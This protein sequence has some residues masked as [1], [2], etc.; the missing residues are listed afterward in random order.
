MHMDHDQSS[1]S[2]RSVR[3]W[4]SM[5]ETV[6]YP[7]TNRPILISLGGAILLLV[8]GCSPPD[9]KSLDLCRNS[10]PRTSQGESLTREDVGELIEACM[11]KRG[12]SL[13]KTGKRCSHDL[14]SQHDRRCYFPDT[15]AGQFFASLPEL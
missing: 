8:G 15:T 7:S 10:A 11:S 5:R 1:V 12:F 14:N 4:G 9:Q 3:L 2:M 6:R 13:L